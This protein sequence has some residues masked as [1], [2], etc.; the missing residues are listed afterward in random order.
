MKRRIRSEA[1]VNQAAEQVARLYRALADLRATVGAV[2]PAQYALLAE[3]PNDQIREILADLDEFAGLREAGPDVPDIWVRVVGRGVSW[4]SAATSVVTSVLDTLRKGLQA[5]TEHAVR[6]ALS[7]RP[8]SELKE[9]CDLRIVALAP[10]SL[11]VGLRA[12]V[13]SEFASEVERSLADYLLAASWAGREGDGAEL[14]RI[15]PEQ[16]R[17]QVVLAELR[18]LAPRP[19]GRIE[20]I[21]LAGLEIR[22]E[23]PAVLRRE[24]RDRIDSGMQQL[25]SQVERVAHEGV[26]R[27]IDLDNRT[28]ILRNVGEDTEIRC[29]FDE[30]LIESAK[31]ALDKRVRVQGTRALATTTRAQPPIDARTID[32]LEPDSEVAP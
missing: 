17:R 30:S 13:G 7:V 20:S 16:E 2:S 31:D 10:G 19:R 4:P 25:E 24:S 3:G 15:L 11:R 12:P 18:R 6:G 27:E 26:L 22:P 21:E 14:A 32:I 8:T 1:E 5:I 23:L 28:F 29:R 9:A